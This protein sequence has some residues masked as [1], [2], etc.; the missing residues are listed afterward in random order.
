MVLV[1]SSV[2]IDHLRKPI[3]EFYE[4]LE[5]NNVLAHPLL[6]G[7]IAMGSLKNRAP[8]LQSLSELPMAILAR[9][10]EVLRMVENEALHGLG[11]GYIDAHLLA[12]TRLTSDAELWTRDKRLDSIAEALGLRYTP[13]PRP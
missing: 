5:R 8:F 10:E 1:D 12:A 4:L 3:L 7:E 6:I 11:I 13:I 2:W 9:E